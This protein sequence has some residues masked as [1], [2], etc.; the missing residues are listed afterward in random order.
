MRKSFF[1]T[2]LLTL[3][4]TL[5]AWAEAYSPQA[6]DY[7]MLKNRKYGTW[8]SASNL[9]YVFGVTATTTDI[10]PE[11]I[12]ELQATDITDAYK[13]YN[14][15]SYKYVGTIP[16]DQ[17]AAILSLWSED[18]ENAG[19]YKFTTFTDTEGNYTT[20]YGYNPD[21][22]DGNKYMYHTD[23]Q[24]KMIIRGS[25]EDKASHW[26]IT[27]VCPINITYGDNG[28]PEIETFVKSGTTYTIDNQG[29]T[30][31]SCIVNG[32]PIEAN[33]GVWSVVVTE[34]TTIYVTFE[35]VV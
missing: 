6:G 13:L 35:E 16:T 24:D 34:A 27:E 14:K 8:L 3:C 29:K 9:W 1:L 18:S 33:N 4:C 10:E 21:V 28:T 12:W 11:L 17:T 5:T 22:N 20:L 23:W 31:K 30:I 15:K 32:Q 19:K 26:T 7:I 2:L 25:N